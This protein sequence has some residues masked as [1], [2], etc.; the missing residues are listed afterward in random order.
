MAGLLRASLAPG[1]TLSIEAPAELPGVTIDPIQIRQVLLNL[2]TNASEAIAGS[3]RVVLRTGVVDAGRADLASTLRRR[4]PAS[5]PLRVPRGGRRRHR[6]ERGDAPPALR[7]RSSAPSSPGRGLG[8][9]ASLGIVR[10]HRGAISVESAP[11]EGARFRVLLPIGRRA[12]RPA[13]A[14]ARG[15]RGRAG[16]ADTSSSIDDEVSVLRTASRS[17][18]SAAAT[19][20]PRPRTAA[21]RLDL[22]TKDPA[23]FAA[24]VLD[25]TMPVMGGAETLQHLRA[26]ARDVP[27]IL[28]SGYSE[29][30]VRERFGR[31]GHAV[32]VEKPFRV[33]ALL[34]AVQS[35]LE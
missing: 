1:V 13:V 9:A 7:S 24:V 25:L 14:C 31:P 33:D 35:V 23:T 12:A 18:R 19:R 2:L 11:G 28:C 8:L 27:V 32:V 5:R 16:A 4:R 15:A 21:R 3:G 22:F 10:A 30:Q 29:E 34:A 6:H 20:S 17:A 26:L